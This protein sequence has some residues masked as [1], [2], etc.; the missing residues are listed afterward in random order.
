I[1]P[2]EPEHEH[3][4]R[5]RSGATAGFMDGPIHVFGSS[6]HAHEIGSVLWSELWRD[7][8][9]VQEINRDEPF[10]FDSQH[11]KEVDLEIQPGD[12]IVNHCIYDSTDRDGTT[13]GGPGTGDEMC[14]NTVTYYPK[15]A[16]GF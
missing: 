12:E 8:E 5:C 11:M 10:L 1:P 14:W 7:G 3:V 9:L 16:S 2:G 15:I 13:I 6:M 4:M